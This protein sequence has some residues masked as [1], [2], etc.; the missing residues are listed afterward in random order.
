MREREREREREGILLSVWVIDQT[1]ICVYEG[2]H[3]VMVALAG[4][5]LNDPNIDPGQSCLYFL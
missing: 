1:H 3:S 5:E 4:N 2:A